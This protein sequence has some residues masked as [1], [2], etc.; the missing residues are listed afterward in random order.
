MAYNGLSCSL[1]Q[2]LVQDEDTIVYLKLLTIL[3]A[4]DTVIFAE[5]RVELQAALYGMMHY[6][7]LWKLDINRYN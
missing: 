4:D 2:E 3:Y 1:I 5:S 7:R 6:C